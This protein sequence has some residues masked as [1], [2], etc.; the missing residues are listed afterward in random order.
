ME[1]KDTNEQTAVLG[2]N[3][4]VLQ[5]NKKLNNNNTT[6]IHNNTEIDSIREN[7]LICRICMFIL[8]FSYI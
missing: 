1:L 8:Y 2:V 5:S 4:R 6:Q 7:E 3:G